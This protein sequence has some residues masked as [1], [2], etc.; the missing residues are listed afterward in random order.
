[1]VAHQFGIQ[2]QISDGR[3]YHAAHHFLL[4]KRSACLPHVHLRKISGKPLHPKPQKPKTLHCWHA[5]NVAPGKFLTPKRIVKHDATLHI[6]S[7]LER[8]FQNIPILPQVEKGD[9]TFNLLCE[10]PVDPPQLQQLN[11]NPSHTHTIHT[12]IFVKKLHL[13]WIQSLLSMLA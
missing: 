2:Q 7:L 8:N 13:S 5:K 11:K 6:D 4:Y 12:L 9:H 3:K 1:M 10:A